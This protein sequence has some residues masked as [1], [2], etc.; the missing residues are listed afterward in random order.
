MRI[1]I[2]TADDE[3]EGEEAN[4]VFAN[5]PSKWPLATSKACNAWD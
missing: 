4:F 1:L 3:R 2:A 5:K